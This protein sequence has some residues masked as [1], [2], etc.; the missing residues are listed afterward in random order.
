MADCDF[1]VLPLLFLMKNG[2]SKVPMPLAAT[3]QAALPP[4]AGAI[5]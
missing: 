4:V 5:R 3:V 2:I 1:H